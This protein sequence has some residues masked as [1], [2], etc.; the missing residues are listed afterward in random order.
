M[1][2]EQGPHNTYSLKAA[3]ATPQTQIEWVQLR[4][5]DHMQHITLSHPTSVISLRTNPL[6]GNKALVLLH[7]H[8]SYIC[9]VSSCQPRVT[10]FTFNYCCNIASSKGHGVLCTS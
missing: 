6:A 4:F 10:H 7:V 2:T 3:K 8:I 5:S 9:Q 1:Q